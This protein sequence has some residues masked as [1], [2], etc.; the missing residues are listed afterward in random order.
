[1]QRM[2]FK[3][4]RKR[5]AVFCRTIQAILVLAALTGIV[6]FVVIPSVFHYNKTIQ[7]HMIFLP[8]GEC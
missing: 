3:Y 5:S 6:V 4:G 7:R 8:W 1:M 2:R